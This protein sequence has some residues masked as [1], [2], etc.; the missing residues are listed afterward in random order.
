MSEQ[1]RVSINMI[2]Q[3]LKALE[4]H[5]N[6]LSNNNGGKSLHREVRRRAFEELQKHAFDISDLMQEAYKKSGRLQF[7]LSNNKKYISELNDLE[8][9][10]TDIAE[11]YKFVIE[12]EVESS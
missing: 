6:E 12:V 4:E 1:V 11:S 5:K 3:A 2:E 7:E 10:L 9:K 8:R